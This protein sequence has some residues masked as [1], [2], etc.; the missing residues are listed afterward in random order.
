P[1]MQDAVVQMQMAE[2]RFLQEH[3]QDILAGMDQVTIIPFEGEDMS[4]F[5]VSGDVISCQTAIELLQYIVSSLAY[6]SITLEYPGVS[7]FLLGEDGQRLLTETEQQFHCIID[8]SHLSMKV[9]ECECVDPWSLVYQALHLNEPPLHTSDLDEVSETTNRL[10]PEIIDDIKVF[11]SLVNHLEIVKDETELSNNSAELSSEEDIEHDIYTDQSTMEL[12]G[13]MSEHTDEE[14]QQACKIS[15]DE[16]QDRQL[17]EEAQLLLAIQRSMDTQTSDDFEENELQMALELSLSE[18]AKE[19]TDESLQNALMRSLKDHRTHPHDAINCDTQGDQ[20]ISSEEAGKALDM[21]QLRVL[22]GDETN[23]VVACAALRKVVAGELHSETLEEAHEFYTQYPDI[24]LALQKK[25]TVKINMNE[26]QVSLQ[27]F[28]LFV[29]RC[30]Q[31]LIQILKA[32]QGESNSEQVMER[33]VQ[34]GVKLLPLPEESEEYTHVTQQFFKTLHELRQSICVLEVQRV[35]NAL[36]YNQYELKKRSMLTHSS[37]VPVERVLY[38]GTTEASAKE[39]CHNGFNRSFCGKNG[40][41]SAVL[42]H[43]NHIYI[44]Y[45]I[46]DTP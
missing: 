14:L 25:H 40:E 12:K 10:L 20:F 6:R 16:Y 17:D 41:L 30:R 9:L 21:A 42:I 26:G 23:I 5:K 44:L 46:Y 28:T 37:R 18:Q 39:I 2:L 33:N 19:K 15:R 11:A 45:I 4:G 3:S 13:I 27:G 24:I 36:L 22:A 31:E 35:Q 38:H 32:L 1:D 29:K 43:Y 7:R 8:T 34:R